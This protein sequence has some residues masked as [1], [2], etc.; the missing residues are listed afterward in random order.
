MIEY[1]TYQLSQK[2]ALNRLDLS[3]VREGMLLRFDGK[4]ACV[5]PWPELGDPTLAE[6]IADLKAGRENQLLT[7]AFYAAEQ[8]GNLIAD[9]PEISSHATLPQLNGT[10]VLAAV[11]AGFKATKI[12]RGKDWMRLRKKTQAFIEG[13]PCL[14][15]RIDFNGALTSHREL[16][17]FLGAMP[18]HQIDFI[19]D[20]FSDPK[21]AETWKGFPIAYDR[22][23]PENLDLEHN[24]LIA[25]PTIQSLETIEELAGTHP[26]KV[27]FTSY[28][29]HAVGQLF[30]L[31]EAQRFYK[32]HKVKAPPLCGLVT[33]GLY[34]ETSYASLLGAASPT[35]N[36]PPLEQLI[37]L[38]ENE[39][40]I[41]L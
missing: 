26:E 39:N 17:Q 3:S 36:H 29:D 34:E 2:A 18:R 33:Q 32:K 19:E 13:Y 11:D 25:K 31:Q 30:A 22:V 9:A 38:L 5:H 40:Y 16:S 10:P 35:L 7:R 24:Y 14:R 4:Y 41:A 15:W 8:F 23:I 20:P 28:M 27:I 6:C 37:E 1:A 12:K 21:L